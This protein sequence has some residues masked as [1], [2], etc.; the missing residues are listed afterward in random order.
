MHR[1]KKTTKLA[2]AKHRCASSTS[3]KK[4]KKTIIISNS[5]DGCKGPRLLLIEATV[6]V[7]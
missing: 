7:R 4:S 2:L 1:L 6:G 3:K 5:E